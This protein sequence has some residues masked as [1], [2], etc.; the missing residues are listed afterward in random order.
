MKTA[1]IMSWSGGKDSA[2]A[3]Q[4]LL[5]SDEHEVVALMTSVSAEYR[6]ISH[7]GVREELLD[8]QA[9]AI[10]LPLEKV[11]LPSGPNGGC[12]NDVYEQI[13]AAT[14]TAFRQRDIETVAY[15]DLFLE[16]IRAWREAS[17]AR[18]GMRAVF[19][20]WK[21]DTTEL[22]REVIRSGYRA[23]T[24]CVEGSVGREFAGRLYDDE[25][26]AQLPAG[27]DPCGER[28][29]FHSFVFDGPPFRWPVPVEVGEIV[30]RDGRFY[31]DLLSSRTVAQP[32]CVAELIP[33]V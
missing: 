18:L 28:G 2:V 1:V 12:S 26:L 32:N 24:S 19:P 30:T 8:A 13:M 7:H 10:G 21:R 15:G 6:R 29:E 31:A 27:M 9:D 4:T 25:F 33:Q 11:Y 5:H 14:L 16:D 23:Y 20:I 3:L 22:A 17:L